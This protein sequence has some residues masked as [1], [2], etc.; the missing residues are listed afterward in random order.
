[1]QEKRQSIAWDTAKV[2]NKGKDQKTEESKEGS[3]AKKGIVEVDAQIEDSSQELP[4][5]KLSIEPLP[6]S[7]ARPKSIRKKVQWKTIYS[8]WLLKRGRLWNSKLRHRLFVLQMDDPDCANAARDDVSRAA[9]GEDGV[10]EMND[11]TKTRLVYYSSEKKYIQQSPSGYITLTNIKSISTD[12][13]TTTRSIERYGLYLTTFSSF[14]S[15][16]RTYTLYCPSTKVRDEWA[17]LLRKTIRCNNTATPRTNTLAGATATNEKTG[18]KGQ[19]LYHLSLSSVQRTYTLPGSRLRSVRLVERVDASQ[20]NELKEQSAM[21]TTFFE[22]NVGTKSKKENEEDHSSDEEELKDSFGGID[23]DND[24]DDE[25]EEEKG[26]EGSEEEKKGK[27]SKNIASTL[28]LNNS[29]PTLTS[30]RDVSGH[31]VRETSLL[32][33]KMLELNVMAKQMEFNNETMMEN[34]LKQLKH[35]IFKLRALHASLETTGKMHAKEMAQ[36]R[37]ESA[38]LWWNPYGMLDK[39]NF[40]KCYVA[41]V[42]EHEGNVKYQSRWFEVKGHLLHYYKSDPK[43]TRR[44]RMPKPRGSIDLREVISV[45][46][47]RASFAPALSLELVTEHKHY[48]VTA[49]TQKDYIRWG[50]K[51]QE[52]VNHAKE[53]S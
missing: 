29:I 16:S 35:E 36:L 17:Y 49:S 12:I 23:D 27:E 19:Q 34:K 25:E 9:N 2:G 26:K 24:D 46:A 31:C 51:L 50:Y 42:A 44:K 10:A 28:I 45:R 15:A 21:A 38:C 1:M 8:G 39:P 22:Q 3:A 14:M 47:C 48:I 41:D 30:L 52:A 20:L 40:K 13:N 53:S 33:Q 18:H 32:L 43:D 37:D 11:L 7:S 4:E 6:T 5:S